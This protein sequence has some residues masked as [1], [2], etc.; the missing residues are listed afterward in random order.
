MKHWDALILN[1][2]LFEQSMKNS[3]R[4]NAWMKILSKHRQ[5][6]RTGGG[7]GMNG[8]QGKGVDFCCLCEYQNMNAV[9]DFRTNVMR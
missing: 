1:L 9:V 8:H 5:M 6:T 2:T 7:S 4:E 3:V